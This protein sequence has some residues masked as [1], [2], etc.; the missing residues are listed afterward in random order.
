LIQ[1]TEPPSTPKREENPLEVT[2]SWT[3]VLH[4]LGVLGEPGGSMADAIIA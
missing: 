1:G 3:F 4:W 2:E